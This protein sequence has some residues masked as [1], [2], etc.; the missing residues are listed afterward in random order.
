MFKN[1]PYFFDYNF[2]LTSRNIDINGLNA[3]V[4]R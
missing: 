1:Y 4:L 2:P 3:E